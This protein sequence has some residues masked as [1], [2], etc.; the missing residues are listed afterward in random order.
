MAAA[1]GDPALV[2]KRIMALIRK[3]WAGEDVTAAELQDAVPF[4]G[5]S[6][7]SPEKQLCIFSEVYN[8][9]RGETD[10]TRALTRLETLSS[11]VKI[12]LRSFRREKVAD[13]LFASVEH[14][15][16]L[17]DPVKEAF[18]IQSD[19]HEKTLRA[20][21]GEGR[22]THRQAIFCAD[23]GAAL[24]S[25]LGP[26]RVTVPIRF[27]TRDD[28]FVRG[29][30]EESP[31]A[32]SRV[33][34]EQIRYVSHG[35]ARFK[36]RVT[37]AV[38]LWRASTLCTKEPETVAWL[39]KTL[40]AKSVI[41]DVGANVGIYSLLALSRHPEVRA[42]CFEPDALNF[43]RLTDNL[44]LNAFGERAVAYAMGLSD[45]TRI[46]RF[47]SS[48]FIVGQAENWFA[49]LNEGGK[50]QTGTVVTGCPLYRLD[51]F[52]AEQPDLPSPTHIKIDVD[53]PELQILKGA[54]ATL[55]RPSLRHILIELFD[56]ELEEV[57]AVLSDHGFKR[58]GGRRHLVV[59]GRGHVG[60]HI[61]RR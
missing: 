54:A 41:Y 46:A 53:G 42:V 59:P 21:V 3:V 26:Q 14:G 5:F 15:R 25:T 31:G 2:H 27:Q 23:N 52:M 39:S 32:G 55:A 20:A 8:V 37:N 50:E 60:N 38:E 29:Q 35:D 51:A 17:T 48:R 47:H 9:V 12:A 49:G 61:F 4:T 13:A 19:F 45:Q 30:R 34:F 22:L 10:L 28:L 6:L 40:D 43:A 33:R 7:L 11:R 57:A 56:D 18:G 36:M 58:S 44:H 16:P 1:P 24:N